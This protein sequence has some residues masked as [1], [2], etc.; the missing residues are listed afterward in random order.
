VAQFSV[1]GVVS[2]EILVR[3]EGSIARFANAVGA[4][5]V[6]ASV[7]PTGLNVWRGR[8]EGWPAEESV[9][10]ELSLVLTSAK[11]DTPAVQA[12]RERVSEIHISSGRLEPGHGH[13]ARCR[14][15]AVRR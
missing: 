10:P 15:P 9:P 14:G 2:L 11:E 12:K 7:G 4:I 1:A 5:L 6:E 8:L 3:P 13:R